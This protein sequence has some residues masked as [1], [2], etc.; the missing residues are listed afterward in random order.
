MITMFSR[1]PNKRLFLIFHGRFPSEKAA[2]LFAAKSAEVFADKGLSV[3]LVAP[4]RLGRLEE[5]AFKFYGLKENFKV[6]FLPTIDLFKVPFLK[7]FAF[8]VSFGLFSL[9][10][11]LYLLFRAK[12]GDII[13][14][15]ESLPLLMAS[16][17][18]PKTVYEI[19]DFPR[20]NFYYRAVFRRVAFFIATNRW[21]KGKLLEIF[22]IS[23]EKITVE[24]NAVSLEEFGRV[25][26][27]EEARKTLSFPLE[28]KLV[29]YVGALRTMGME[30]G[31]GILLEAFKSV[32]GC[33]LLVVGGSVE[34]VE[35]YKK[36][37]HDYG[38]IDRIIFTG[39]VSHKQ[40]PLYLRAADI[41]VAPFPKSDHYEFYMSPMKIFEY[42][43][44]GR[45]IVATDLESIREILDNGTAVFVKPDDQKSL[46]EGINKLL[47]DEQFGVQIADKA[48]QKV[49]QHTWG[50]R[51]GRIL[52]FL[53]L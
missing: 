33:Q 16:F 21:K 53:G 2:A 43:A 45:P 4:R 36:V 15:N 6:V 30:K 49:L 14:S 19:H 22:K 41:L 7:R 18:F 50:K 46:E 32:A 1:L 24:Q 42:M 12:P 29:C 27:R 3:V 10:S 28:T 35:F 38:I 40:V 17:A 26:S 20:N 52:E 5:S 31:I 25:A 9:F 8:P 23:E 51:A 13:Y 48:Y 11:F 39:F 37:A 47:T 34:D 44:S